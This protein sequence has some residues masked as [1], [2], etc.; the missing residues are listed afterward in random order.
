MVET[1]TYSIEGPDGDVEE[2]E[3]PAGL[4][5]VFAQG[6]DP[7]VVVGDMAVNMLAQQAHVQVHHAEGDVPADLEALNEKMEEL[8]EARFGVSLADA[9]GHSH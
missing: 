3:L 5:E 8:F 1:E 6:E 4:L 9:M 2:I 7:T